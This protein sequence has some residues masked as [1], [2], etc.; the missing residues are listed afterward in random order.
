[1]EMSNE[2]KEISS[3]TVS[4]RAVLKYEDAVSLNQYVQLEKHTDLNLP[5]S[6]W[7][8]DNM[9]G[10]FATQK[11][12]ETFDCSSLF[13]ANKYPEL[14]GEVDVISA[15]DHIKKLLK[16][17]FSNS[18]LSMS[19]HCI[20]K[21]LLLNEIDVP[22]LLQQSSIYC[23]DPNLQWLHDLYCS[24][25]N[26]PLG[27]ELL[28]K[29]RNKLKSEIETIHS[30]FMY[31]STED[32]VPN[33]TNESTAHSDDIIKF[34]SLPSSQEENTDHARQIMNT[35]DNVKNPESSI[36][37][38]SCFL[39]DV[40]WTFEDITMLVGSN[41]PI[42]GGGKYPAVSLR[43]RD[44][45]KPIS[46]LT[47]IDYWLDNL[48][49]NVPE[50]IMC[51]HLKGIVQKYEQLKTTD[52]PQLEGSSFSPGV[53]RDVAQNI[54]SFLKANCTKE[55]H[56]YWL[57]KST[58]DDIIKLYDLTSICSNSSV[59]QHNPF[60]I[61]VALLLYQIARN[62]I[63][64]NEIT[65]QNITR[66]RALL[67][68]C[69]L[70]L[71]KGGRPDISFLANYLLAELYGD[72]YK[73]INT[74][75]CDETDDD[76]SRSNTDDELNENE[77]S[78]KA[79]T[80]SVN[81][82]RVPARRRR[83][84]VHFEVPLSSLDKEC[85]CKKSLC[86]ISKALGWLDS[87]SEEA[88]MNDESNNPQSEAKLCESKSQ[89]VAIQQ[90]GKTTLDLIS[91]DMQILKMPLSSQPK[92]SISYAIMKDGLLETAARCYLT[93][94]DIN[95]TKKKFGR[96]LRFVQISCFCLMSVKKQSLEC[97]YLSV[98]SLM[99][100]GDLLTMLVKTTTNKDSEKEDFT[101]PNDIDVRFIAL[102]KPSDDCELYDVN[103]KAICDCFERTDEEL[104]LCSVSLYEKAVKRTGDEK[105]ENV[106]T[107]II[108]LTRRLGNVRNELGVLHMNKAALMAKKYGIPS[109]QEVE[110][111][112]ISFDY[113]EN[114]IR[115]FEVA[116]DKVN[117]ALVYANRGRLMC[118]CAQVYGYSTRSKFE[119]S[120]GQFTQQEKTYFGKAFEYYHKALLLL[121]RQEKSSIWINVS[122]ELSGAYF[123]MATVLQDYA[124]LNSMAEEKVI[125]EVSSS[126]MKVL[127]Y[128]EPVLQHCSEQQRD[129]V[130]LRLGMVHQRLASLYHHVLRNQLSDHGKK[131]YR[132]LAELH[133]KKVY[134]I[135]NPCTY[136]LE[137]LR[138]IVLHAALFDYML[139]QA[140]TGRTLKSKL[141]MFLHKDVES[142][143]NLLSALKE[144]L[145]QLNL[146]SE[147]K[148]YDDM[149][150]LTKA[151]TLIGEQ[152]NSTIKDVLKL[153][154]HKKQ[155]DGLDL[156]TVKRLYEILLRGVN[157]KE[158]DIERKV[159]GLASVLS[160][161]KMEYA[162]I[163]L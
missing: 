128:G 81:N 117:L 64:S 37:A 109:D 115:A 160:D 95:V 30:K 82:L 83:K 131:N 33:S 89:T 59:E 48:M 161:M 111:W 6:N 28:P 9:A 70:L 56:T 87:L 79:V 18:E 24:A 80:V 52:L 69:D 27:S 130:V 61:T 124:P 54:L 113:F 14:I 112:K 129:V 151:L 62:I 148:L 40:L 77:N 2:S 86:F 118:L 43:L 141:D 138:V 155:K 50:L 46:I 74:S 31:Y 8:R 20:G 36:P 107:Q 144:V 47:G 68:N 157:N 34:E 73:N 139:K 84:S 12:K 17:P 103:V 123:M 106:M 26:I 58:K 105:E 101:S 127:Q 78:F 22:R 136:L 150:E 94:S 152:L 158:N 67:Q 63:S 71:E 137:N 154:S 85:K 13:M 126:L 143:R 159:R 3:Q 91:K 146:K 51:Y 102:L 57:Y 7:L 156:S 125:K 75:S 1:M 121:N 104:L 41:L 21:S 5:P 142:S 98:K 153:L 132:S 49:C 163:K 42:F 135:L 15:A 147:S 10:R 100:Y 72:I 32:K 110:L 44:S 35:V 65:E 140:S 116:N 38:S 45:S 29:K 145:N 19:V 55:G 66:V 122:I 93:L 16:T 25:A 162:D 88:T 149:D 23:G 39:R 76:T 96:A 108:E 60:S 119:E 97:T 99:L 90:Q 120:R 4:S 133:Y 53:I 11:T 92:S 134:T 114:S